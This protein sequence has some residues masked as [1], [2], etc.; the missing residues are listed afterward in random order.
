MWDFT[1]VLFSPIGSQDISQIIDSIIIIR[2]RVSRTVV[3]YHELVS[4][5]FLIR[6][7]CYYSNHN[8]NFRILAMYFFSS[9]ITHARSAISV[10][11]SLHASDVDYCMNFRTLAMHFFSFWTHARS[12][13]LVIQLYMS[14]LLMHHYK[15]NCCIIRLHVQFEVSSIYRILVI[16]S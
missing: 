16:I 8:M 4:Y 6:L 3:Y 5:M 13:I 9:L 2:P 15:I 14:K 11:S 1:S 10:T 12:N 7:P